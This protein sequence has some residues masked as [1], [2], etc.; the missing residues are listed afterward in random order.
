MAPLSNVGHSLGSPEGGS[1][2][3]GAILG[4]RLPVGEKVGSPVGASLGIVDE[5]GT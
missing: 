3:V 5:L 4:T 2:I 1:D